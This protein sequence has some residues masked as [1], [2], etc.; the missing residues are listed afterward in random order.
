MGA[1]SKLSIPRDR[2]VRTIISDLTKLYL[3]NRTRISRLVWIT[4][5]VALV[6]RVRNAISEQ[7]A[8]SQR[9]AEKR[10]AR[11]ATVSTE[12]EATKKKKKVELNREFFRSL[13]RLLRIVV[14]G[15]RSKE[16]RLLISHSFFLIVRTLISLKVAAMDGAIV[17]SLVKGNGREFLMRIVWWMV[18]A[19]PATF[20]NSMVRVKISQWCCS[21]ANGS[22]ALLSPSRTLIEVPDAIDT[23]Y[24]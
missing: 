2:T 1:Q 9:D 18:I 6:N 13:L 12:R 21:D 22:L 15:W 24:S 5:F 20:T 23:T 14:P 19:V 4:L 7:K 11:S 3:S 17:K 16:T 8:A 10:A